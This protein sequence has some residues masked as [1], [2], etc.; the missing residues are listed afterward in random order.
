MRQN[1]I[2][3]CAY[4]HTHFL[5]CMRHYLYCSI[6]VV[7]CSFPF[8]FIS[9][10]FLHTH[11]QIACAPDKLFDG[12]ATIKTHSFLTYVRVRYCIFNHHHCWCNVKNWPQSFRC[13]CAIVSIFKKYT[14]WNNLKRFIRS[15][16][17]SVLFFMFFFS[18]LFAQLR[19]LANWPCLLFYLTQHQHLMMADT[20]RNL[21]TCVTHLKFDCFWIC[22]RTMSQSTE[23]TSEPLKHR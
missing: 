11:A 23:F 7:E 22:A 21:C 9:L 18:H 20:Q 3:V 16:G 1:T 15:I 8:L 2:C 5:Y 19:K 17:Q 12:S 10:S 13:W 4:T 14:K 6:A